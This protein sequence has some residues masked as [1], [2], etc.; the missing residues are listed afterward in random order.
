MAIERDIFFCGVPVW[1][2]LIRPSD[3]AK[4]Y[5]TLEGGIAEVSVFSPYRVH[6]KEGEVDQVYNRTGLVNPE[7]VIFK[8]KLPYVRY[9]MRYAVRK[10][11]LLDKVR[12]LRSHFK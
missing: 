1:S 12:Y 7:G 9:R 5:K 10:S 2:S 3:K 8:S 6:V 11:T 4:L